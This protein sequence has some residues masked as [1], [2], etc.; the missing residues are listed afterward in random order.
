MQTPYFVQDYEGWFGGDP[1]EVVSQT[2]DLIPRIDGDLH[3]AR[4][5][6]AARHAHEATV[7]PMSAD[8]R[9]STPARADGRRA[10]GRSSP[11]SAPTS[12]RGA[13]YLLPALAEVSRQPGIEIRP[14]RRAR[15]PEGRRLVPSPPRRRPVARGGRAAP[16]GGRRSSS[17][18]ALP[19]VRPRRPGG[20]ACGA[21]CVLTT[22]AASARRPVGLRE[23]PDRPAARTERALAEA[24]PQ[25]RVRF[26]HEEAPRRG[27]DRHG[28]ALHVRG[29]R[30]T[31]AGLLAFSGLAAARRCPASSRRRGPAAGAPLAPERVAMAG[32]GHL[33][34]E[35]APPRRSSNPVTPG[36]LAA[37]TRDRRGLLE[38]KAKLT[39]R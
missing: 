10:A 2:Y 15:G 16:V 25:A 24:I 33:H 27:R 32:D 4:R 7:V 17:T 26:R 22:A 30:R 31:R 12:G 5:E 20:M 14:L 9:S 19:G 8:P 18:V 6:L 38:V 3:L 23:R 21:A 29:P 34:L 37:L 28:A 11:A 1:P 35:R 13:R 36:R 39:G